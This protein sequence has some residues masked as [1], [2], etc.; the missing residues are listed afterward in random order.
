VSSDRETTRIVRSWLDEGVT[1]LPDRVLNAVL[2]QVP[3]TPQRRTSWF[4]R[5]F[6]DVSNIAR[7]GLA[8]A[9][10]VLAA[11]LGANLI[12]RDGLG[13]GTPS[14]T[15]VASATPAAA[16]NEKSLNQLRGAA[17][18]YYLD[19]PFPARITFDVPD[20]W[21]YWGN[22]SDVQGLLV[23]G[24]SGW[25]IAFS[26]VADVYRDPCDPNPRVIDLPAIVSVD[27]LVEAL[28]VL[29]GVEASPPVEIRI[30]GFEGKLIE[31]TAT[32]DRADCLTVNAG[33]WTSPG[34][35]DI[36]LS[37]GAISRVNQIRILDV[38]GTPVA[39]W[40]S[41]FPETT[42]FEEGQGVPLDPERHAD[43]QIDMQQILDSVRIRTD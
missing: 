8:A 42:E 34:G 10:V 40:T 22:A 38:S 11:A 15:A 4:G 28:S 39:I 1:R 36:G 3:A 43:D 24:S 6:F 2:D 14:T 5:S 16:P 41:D 27:E 26:L 20:G 13:E 9:A 33:L 37:V 18:T 7:L 17:G 30:D 32:Y 25:G 19:A 12:A 23:D 35:G 31:L 21:E 29:P